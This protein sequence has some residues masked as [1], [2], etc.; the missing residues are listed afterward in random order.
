MK[1]PNRDLLFLPKKDFG[2]QKDVEMEV[3]KLHEMLF[4]AECMENFCTVN[5]IIDLNVYKV[6]TNRVKIE[7]II[8]Q[9]S[10]KPFQ[11]INNKN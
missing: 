3:E 5:E 11:F 9:R 8:R 4:H 7:K 10:M 6:I 2:N 1:S